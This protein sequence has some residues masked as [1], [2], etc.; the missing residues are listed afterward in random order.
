MIL[1][2]IRILNG[3]CSH[4]CQHDIKSLHETK[5][6]PCCLKTNAKVVHSPQLI[7]SF[8]MHT[9]TPLM[10]NYWLT[11]ALRLND[12]CVWHNAFCRPVQVN[13]GS[14]KPIAYASKTPFKRWNPLVDNRERNYWRLSGPLSTSDLTCM[15]AYSRSIQIV[16]PDLD[17]GFVS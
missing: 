6:L 15:V 10:Q 4:Q 11:I 7:E 14:D 8:Q 12:R 1:P 17:L 5:P 9:S 13:I 3:C 16:D 2:L